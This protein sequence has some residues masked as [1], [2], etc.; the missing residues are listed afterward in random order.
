[1]VDEDLVD[2]AGA[3]VSRWNPSLALRGQ[4]LKPWRDL[5]VNDLCCKA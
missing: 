5:A 2:A 1:M 4:C 3:Q